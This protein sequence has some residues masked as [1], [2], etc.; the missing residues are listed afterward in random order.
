MIQ[1]TLVLY[2]YHDRP[3]QTD[4]VKCYITCSKLP[5]RDPNNF[6]VTQMLHT[7]KAKTLK[8]LTMQ[9]LSDASAIAFLFLMKLRYG[10]SVADLCALLS[11]LI[12][13]P[14]DEFVEEN[15]LAPPPEGTC[16]C[17]QLSV[18]GGDGFNCGI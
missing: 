9:A 2:I 17:S 8:V 10:F 11:A 5:T 1:V 18:Y 6:D 4:G 16:F 14:S 7:L 13:R 12:P 3:S 15:I